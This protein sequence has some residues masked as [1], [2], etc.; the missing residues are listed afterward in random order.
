MTDRAVLEMAAKAA[1]IEFHNENNNGSGG[2]WIKVEP[3]PGVFP[4]HYQS[5][6]PFT[7]DGDALRLA[8]A[9]KLSC[10]YYTGVIE[11]V[12][13]DKTGFNRCFDYRLRNGGGDLYAD[14]RRAIVYAA[15]AIGK[16][17]P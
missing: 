1:G 6:N 15:A 8:V 5:W 13:H 12:E 10:R 3:I 17:M 7:D 11:V 14:T 9:L 16:D 4:T 2:R